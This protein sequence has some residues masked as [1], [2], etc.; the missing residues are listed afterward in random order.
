MTNKISIGLPLN[1]DV[2]L[3]GVFLMYLGRV[4][5]QIREKL[6][7]RL[8]I[9]FALV[10]LSLGSFMSFLNT[11]LSLTPN[12]PHVEMAVGS[13]GNVVLFIINSFCITLGLILLSERVMLMKVSKIAYLK[14]C[15]IFLGTNSMTILCTH[16]IFLNIIRAILL[17]FL[18]NDTFLSF[19]AC[20]ITLLVIYPIIPILKEYLPELIGA[21]KKQ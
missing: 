6:K 21:A 5:R 1:V 20:L 9:F 19:L 7:P 17:R 8:L 2:A 14:D 11:P 12:C 3:V 18:P 15:L 16:G 4:M 10:M 13:Y